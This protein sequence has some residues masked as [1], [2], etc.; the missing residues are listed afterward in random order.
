MNTQLNPKIV[1]LIAADLGVDSA[2]VEKDWYAMRIIAAM[3][4]V[5]SNMRLVFSGGTSLS[6]GF[7]LI[8]RFSEDLDFK[9]IL[10]STGFDRKEARNYRHLLVD[11]I[12]KASSDWSLE[13][14]DCESRNKG[15]FFVCKIAYQQNFQP[16]V[17]LRPHIKL[18]I[19]FKPPVL[20]L[21]VQEKPL[22]SFIAQAT[23]NGKPEV[24]MIAC[25]SPVE[26]AADKLSVLTW[27][28]LSRNREHENDDPTIIRHL[29]D[30]TALEDFITKYKDFSNLVVSLLEQDAQ[31][32][33]GINLSEIP[34]KQRLQ[35]MLQYLESDPIYANEY[36]LFV[37]GMSYAL[38]DD[39]PSFSQA[40]DTVRSII[41]RI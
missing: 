41:S 34:P 22:Q 30:L 10:P 26:T 21:Q 24:P 13:D 27:R 7:G 20:P 19:T 4:T 15:Q 11:A 3:I 17:A 37:N 8:Q 16:A 25:V 6:K 23:P 35:K 1:E 9:I 32:A 28:V 31:R 36:D 18:E 33:K 40:L 12:R 39:R 38:E 29:H 2:F 14:E 5:K